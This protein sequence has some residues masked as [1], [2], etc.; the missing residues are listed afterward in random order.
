[1]D[2]RGSDVPAVLSIPLKKAMADTNLRKKRRTQAGPDAATMKFMRKL[3]GVLV[4]AA[5]AGAFGT[6]LRAQSSAAAGSLE[7][8]AFVS[9]TAAKPEPVRDFTFYVLIKSYEDIKKEVE[10]K[11]GAP[12]REKIIEGLKLSPELREWL[13]A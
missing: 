12:D 3:Y 6:S 1:M 2:N 8:S 5:V 13:K 9:P 10:T 4:A 11:N 7:F